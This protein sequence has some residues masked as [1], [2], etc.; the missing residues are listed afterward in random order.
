MTDT[1]SFFIKSA[2]NSG[3]LTAALSSVRLLK[4]QIV[5]KSNAVLINFNGII[6]DFR[7]QYAILM[8]VRLFSLQNKL[9][10]HINKGC[11]I[12][13]KYLSCVAV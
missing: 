6:C 10:R 1:F 11:S 2:Q 8:F 13:H 4:L 12:F 5:K 3:C 9:L 7:I